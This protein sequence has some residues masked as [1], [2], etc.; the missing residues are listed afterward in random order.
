MRKLQTKDVFNAM[1]LIKKANVREEIKPIIKLAAEGS[2][3]V[4]DIGIEGILTVFE[5]FSEKKAEDA[6]YEFLC[7]PLEIGKEE[8]ESLELM[9]LAEKLEEFA[10]ENDIKAFFTILSGMITSK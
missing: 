10:K 6:I 9:E 3:G 2:L 1:R 5:I 4:V 8:L 7:E